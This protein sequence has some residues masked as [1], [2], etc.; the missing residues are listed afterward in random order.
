MDIEMLKY[1]T[2]RLSFSPALDAAKRE[3]LIDRIAA[4]PALI[5]AAVEGLSDE[6]L[7]T[8]YR[9]GGWTIRQVVHHLPDSHLN[10]YVRFKLAITE[11]KPTIR[12]YDQGAWADTVDSRTGP[13]GPSLD[14]L[15]ALHRRWADWL[16]T[17]TPEQWKRRFQHPEMGE[18]SLDQNLQVY[19]WHGHHHLGHIT[20]L[21]TQMN[22]S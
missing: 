14:L 5:R 8:P 11:D 18:V 17:L 3:Q 6:Q 16:R 2:G 10:S 22:W 12:T 13:V 4:V 9:P 7:D 21:K 19:A 1:P 20:N 15:E